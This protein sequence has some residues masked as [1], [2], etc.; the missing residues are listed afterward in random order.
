MIIVLSIEKE[1]IGLS[2]S[3]E[4]VRTAVY[5]N[6]RE[7]GGTPSTT[8]T[9]TT[10]ATPT[11]N[12]YLQAPPPSSGVRF[13]AYQSS[14][15]EISHQQQPQMSSSEE[16]DHEGSNTF[17]DK[18]RGTT[19]KTIQQAEEGFIKLDHAIRQIRTNIQKK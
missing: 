3:F 14:E 11:P 1:N 17:M 6:I 16:D 12:E 10:T 2:D 9:T 4:N 5:N 13:Y 8:T 15:N 18:V 7:L 19:K